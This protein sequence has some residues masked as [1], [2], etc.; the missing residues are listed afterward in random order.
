LSHRF[1]MLRDQQLEHL[2]AGQPLTE[3][4]RGLAHYA[5]EDVVRRLAPDER[6]GLSGLRRPISRRAEPPT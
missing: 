3:L 6:L 5:V 4:R 2:I 1:I